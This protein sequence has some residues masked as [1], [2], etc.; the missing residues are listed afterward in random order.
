MELSSQTS[1]MMFFGKMFIFMSAFCRRF[2][3]PRV[4]KPPPE[5]DL[6][7]GVLALGDG[8]GGGMGACVWWSPR[9]RGS[10]CNLAIS[11]AVFARPPLERGELSGVDNISLK[12]ETEEVNKLE[13]QQSVQIIVPKTIT[14]AIDPCFDSLYQLLQVQGTG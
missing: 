9:A 6:C 8:G 2:F 4:M 10:A 7:A 14:K 13:S 3:G 1:V 11:P 5:L 12:T